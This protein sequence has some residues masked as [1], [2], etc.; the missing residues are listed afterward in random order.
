[1]VVITSANRTLRVYVLS[2][3]LSP[4]VLIGD[5]GEGRLVY[6]EYSAQLMFHQPGGGFV[7]WS[8]LHHTFVHYADL[9]SSSK[10]PAQQCMQN[11]QKTTVQYLKS[12]I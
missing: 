7:W 1:M 8:P 11:K 9:N 12:A 10:A 5:V 3:R 2:H 6:N 4:T